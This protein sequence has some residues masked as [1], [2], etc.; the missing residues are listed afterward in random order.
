MPAASV[1]EIYVNN[2]KILSIFSYVFH[3]TIMILKLK[4]E[5]LEYGEY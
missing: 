2:P 3:G 4:S 5:L 1:F